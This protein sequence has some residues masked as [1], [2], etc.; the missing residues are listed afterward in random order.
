MVFTLFRTS[1]L[2]IA[3][4]PAT[5]PALGSG[6]SDST[7]THVDSLRRVAA[8]LHATGHYSQAVRV[9][10]SVGADTGD[11][12]DRFGLSL[13]YAAL[14]NFTE[15]NRFLRHTARFGKRELSVSVRSLSRPSRAHQ[16]GP[17]SIRENHRI[18]L[19]LHPGIVCT[20]IDLQ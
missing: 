6:F 10:L 5:V 16:R 7:D 14:N 9:F 8:S 18:G 4:L 20:R 2:A 15:A 19:G 11:A 3:L 17:G 12:R 1:V 13:S